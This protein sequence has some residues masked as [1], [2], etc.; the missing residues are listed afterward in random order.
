MCDPDTTVFSLWW[1]MLVLK[2][3]CGLMVQ[4]LIPV[5]LEPILVHPVFNSCRKRPHSELA[6]QRLGFISVSVLTCSRLCL[7]SVLTQG[8]Q[9]FGDL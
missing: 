3:V 1:K 7:I 9:G 4:D 8:A 2:L 6:G 5:S